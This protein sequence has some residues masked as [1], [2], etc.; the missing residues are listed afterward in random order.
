LKRNK[1]GAPIGSSIL[2][3]AVTSLMVVVVPFIPNPDIFWGFFALQ[4]I[5]LFFAYLLMFPAFKKLRKID[6]NIERPFKTPGSPFMISLIA[7]VPL[8]LLII[9]AIFSI[10]YPLADGSWYFDSMI[11]VGTVAAVLVGEAIV[12]TTRRGRKRA[13]QRQSSMSVQTA[14]K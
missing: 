7:Y 8:V 5:T 1:E 6:P 9:S 13:K 14:K 3:G 4:I 10:V 12:F 2:I 11:A